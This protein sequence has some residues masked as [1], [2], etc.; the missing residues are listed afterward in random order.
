MTRTKNIAS[1]TLLTSKPLKYETLLKI[2]LNNRSQLLFKFIDKSLLSCSLNNQMAHMKYILLLTFLACL[3]P[4]NVEMLQCYQCVDTKD[5]EC[6][7]NTVEPVN[8]TK[9]MRMADNDVNMG[10]WVKCQDSQSNSVHCV[11][12]SSCYINNLPNQCGGIGI[13]KQLNMTDMTS[14]IFFRCCFV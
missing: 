9:G 7:L 2:S 12:F 14:I 5:F 10:Q 6:F 1:I 4:N 13:I 8:E 3:L 11:D